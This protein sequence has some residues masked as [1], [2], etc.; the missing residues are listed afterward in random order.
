MLSVAVGSALFAVSGWAVAGHNRMVVSEFEVGAA[1]ALTVQVRPGVQF[2]PAVRRRSTG[3]SAMAVVVEHGSDGE[4]LAVDSQRFASV[5]SWPAGLTPKSASAIAAAIGGTSVPAVMLGD[6]A[7]RVS[8]DLGR[9]IVP[10]P[11]LQATVFDDAYDTQSTV[12]L[13]SSCPGHTTTRHR[14]SGT[15]LGSC[16]LVSLGVTWSA[17]VDSSAQTVAVPLRI[18]SLAVPAASGS[19]TPL[20]AGL[21]RAPSLAEPVDRRGRRLLPPGPDREGVSLMP[22]GARRRSGPPTCPAPFLPW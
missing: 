6:R 4:T 15:A 18:T 19:W 11:Q 8:V 9:S 2:E 16:R 12:E 7:I 10:A 5:A 3:H 1:K 13:G 14:L 21:T 20:E 22:R 17:P